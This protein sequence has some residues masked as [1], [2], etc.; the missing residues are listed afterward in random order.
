[1][2]Y[3][4]VG[5][6]ISGATV[7]ER[8]ASETGTR[9]RVIDRRDR[10][11]GL[12]ADGIDEGSGALVGKYGPRLLHTDN[13]IV[14]R[15]LSG[16]A[17]WR[18]WTMV[19]ACVMPD[20]RHAPWPPNI[21]TIN[22]RDDSHA[23]TVDEIGRPEGVD[24]SFDSRTF[25]ERY[26]A[27]PDGGWSKLIDRILQH[28]LI[29]VDLG[30]DFHSI[31]ADELSRYTA[32]IWAAPIDAYFRLALPYLTIKYDYYR[33][34]GFM[35]Y[36]L[37]FP[38]VR[39]SDDKTL[40]DYAHFPGNW[41][42][43]G[44]VVRETRREANPENGDEPLIPCPEAASEFRRLPRLAEEAAPSASAMFVRR[45]STPYERIDAAV[46]E[47]LRFFT[48]RIASGSL[49]ESVAASHAIVVARHTE[50]VGW[51]REM[52]LT[53]TWIRDIVVVNKGR[54]M[55]SP[56]PDVIRIKNAPNVGREGETYLSYI[57]E[58]Y[59]DLPEHMWF[60]Q[61]NPLEHS[62]DFFGLLSMDSVTSYDLR[63]GF[64]PLSWR[65]SRKL[66]PGDVSRDGRFH[67][68]GNRVV[69]YFIRSDTQQV[70]EMHEFSDAAHR[71]KV[72]RMKERIRDSSNHPDH[73]FAHLCER[74]GLPVPKAVIPYCWASIFYVRR[75]A[76]VRHPKE[77]YAE[78]RRFL[79]ESE[80]QGGVEG[81]MLER[82][83]QYLFT[84][85]SYDTL[86]AVYAHRNLHA[87]D[88]CGTWCQTRR[89]LWI[90]KGVSLQSKTRNSFT[91]LLC[92]DFQG[93]WKEVRG[94]D[95]PGP[96]VACMPCATVNQAKQMLS[97]FAARKKSSTDAEIMSS[98]DR[99][100]F[101]SN[102]SAMRPSIMS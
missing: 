57:L 54:E 43:R 49:G 5:A 2:T 31:P 90:K 34:P 100:S 28:D 25:R 89:R 82:F 37:P 97:S 53:N 65:Y 24:N 38:V 101:N 27:F 72:E 4:V 52:A 1:M 77:T 56:L 66:P 13:E 35:G 69:Q 10:T 81:Y 93:G 96:S 61:G 74:I 48:E 60:T 14:W 15:Y 45:T 59:D 19:Q 80:P 51:V 12:C 42:G 44:V 26:Q 84:L 36:K 16:F 58:N 64:Q 7:A 63:D 22:V 99:A 68:K 92:S 79:M 102:L 8:I 86:D 75:D 95:L 67:V 85:E 32:V 91:T 11:S 6:G 20:G 9:V 98:T 55:E 71:A 29:T 76:V 17:K 62:P 46:A 47:S 39:E 94:S 50:D 30:V 18:R 3:L 21:E 33:S 23:R 70:T 73:F 88:V 40:V 41:M 83:W 78:L 87:A